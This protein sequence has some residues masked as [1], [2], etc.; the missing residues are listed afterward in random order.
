MSCVSGWFCDGRV[1]KTSTDVL[2]TGMSLSLSITDEYESDRCLLV[3]QYSNSGRHIVPVECTVS[4]G[5]S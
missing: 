4:G 5:L 1:G 3:V 2:M